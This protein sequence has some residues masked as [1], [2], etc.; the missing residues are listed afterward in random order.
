[1]SPWKRVLL[2]R[3]VAMVPTI[4]V[5]LLRGT[6]EWSGP[7]PSV[8]A[9]TMRLKLLPHSPS[10]SGQHN[11]LEGLDDWINVLQSLQ[12]PFALFPLLHFTSSRAIMG[13]FA[14]G[15]I[16]TGLG[17]LL[18]CIVVGVNTYLI[19]IT[20][21]D[22]GGEWYLTLTAV[23][24]MVPYALFSLYLAIAPLFRWSKVSRRRAL[25]WF[26]LVVQHSLP[27]SSPSHVLLAQLRQIYYPVDEAQMAEELTQLTTSDALLASSSDDDMEI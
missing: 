12:L 17:W 21:Q 18:A 16:T 1:M 5:A 4:I 2:T 14:S 27:P 13:D 6:C 11:E 15:R 3:S 25:A 20:F 8:I 7:N 19:V 24:I 9:A 22:S 26:L 23:L 10:R